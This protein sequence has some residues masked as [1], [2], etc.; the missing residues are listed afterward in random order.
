ME[1]EGEGRRKEEGEGRWDK[2]E[3]RERGGGRRERGGGRRERGGGGGRGEEGGGRGEEG[4]GRGEEGEGRREEGEG[5]RG[6]ERGGGGER[7]GGKGVR[8]YCISCY[9]LS[10]F[11]NLLSL[12]SSQNFAYGSGLYFQSLNTSTNSNLSV[13]HRNEIQFPAMQYSLNTWELPSR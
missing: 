2:G 6:R 5:R 3:G 9:F 11:M 8:G 12:I 7:G 13:P 4:G 10:H 1:G